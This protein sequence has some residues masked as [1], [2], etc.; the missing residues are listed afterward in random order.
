LKRD[1][2]I[3]LLASSDITAH[4]PRGEAV[5][6]EMT[7]EDHS[8]DWFTTISLSLSLSLFPFWV[9]CMGLEAEVSILNCTIKSSSADIFF[10]LFVCLHF[11]I[12]VNS[13]VVGG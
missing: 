13:R 10:E 12:F 1:P 7:G 4:G 3:T 11:I 6:D 2:K 5:R 9:G 8:Y